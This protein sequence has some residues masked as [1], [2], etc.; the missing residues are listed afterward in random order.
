M[1]H[2]KSYKEVTILFA[3]KLTLEFGKC[4]FN[5]SLNLS[6]E[7]KSFLFSQTLCP[8]FDTIVALRIDDDVAASVIFE[9][10]YFNCNQQQFDLEKA[11][12][13]R[14]R[15]GHVLECWRKEFGVHFEAYAA[16]VVRRPLGHIRGLKEIS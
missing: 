7:L 8:A 13:R 3:K 11:H 5:S 1:C 2:K 9:V 6:N 16:H 15:K 4:Q 12:L 10:G 14:L